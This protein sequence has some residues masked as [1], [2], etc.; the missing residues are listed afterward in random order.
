MIAA[1]GGVAGH[2][3]RLLLMV[4]RGVAAS[5]A[6]APSLFHGYLESV[7]FFAMIPGGL[8]YLVFTHPLSP[9]LA[10][11]LGTGAGVLGVAGRIS[12][13]KFPG[14]SR[15]IA[16]GDINRNA[17][18][19]FGYQA[20]GEKRKVYRVQPAALRCCLNCRELISE[21]AFAVVEQTTNQRAFAVIYAARGNKA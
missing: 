11:T 1:V 19:T 4:R 10:W 17:L 20:I 2:S 14:W 12:D 13:N 7:I 16:I 5:D 18:L 15:K 3:L 8:A 21:Q 9:R 6:M